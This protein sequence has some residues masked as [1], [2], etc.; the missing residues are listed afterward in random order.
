[1]A[2]KTMRSHTVTEYVGDHMESSVV[3]TILTV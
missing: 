2:G 1:M 3:T